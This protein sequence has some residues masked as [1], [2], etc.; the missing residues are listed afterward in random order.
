[1]NFTIKELGIWCLGLILFMTA[2][3]VNYLGAQT[4]AATSGADF[5]AKGYEA[6]PMPVH[7]HKQQHP[8]TVHL[9]AVQGTPVGQP[10]NS[11]TPTITMVPVG[12]VPATPNTH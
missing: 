7:H 1:M 11:Q 6:T 5:N 2:L 3:S 8:M 9:V 10:V 12:T 4:P